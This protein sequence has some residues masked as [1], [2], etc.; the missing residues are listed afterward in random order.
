MDD[1]IHYL[2]RYNREF[3]RDL[4]KDRAMR[5]TVRSVGRP[6]ILTTL[7]ICLGF[8]I[9]TFSQFKPTATF[10][11]LMVMTMGAAL[12]GDLILLPALM[13][14]VELVTA[15]DLLKRMPALEAMSANTAHEL[16]Q[17]LNAIR[18]GSDFLDMMLQKKE[19]IPQG[20]LSHV[21]EEIGAQVDRATAIINRMSQFSKHPGETPEAVDV[22]RAIGDALEMVSHRMALE[23]WLYA[24]RAGRKS[25]R[26]SA[27][28]VID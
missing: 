12:V 3:K 5:D 1:T 21:S 24:P 13:L 28:T 7:M 10:G 15:W 19:T 25:S 6:I 16:R 2:V 27:P 11:V 26:R 23:M 4:N 17:P 22:N 9:L 20:V 18:M 8:S 14:H